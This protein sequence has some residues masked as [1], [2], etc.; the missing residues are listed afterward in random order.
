MN[1]AK[2][3]MLGIISQLPQEQ[4]DEVN[5]LAIQIRE[6]CQKDEGKIAL[7]VVAAEI[8]QEA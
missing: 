7:A 5:R 6:I 2:L 1:T 8:Q 3:L 4:Q